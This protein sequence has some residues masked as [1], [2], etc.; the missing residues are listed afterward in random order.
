MKKGIIKWYRKDGTG[1]IIPDNS[2]ETIYFDK[3]VFCKKYLKME[4]GQKVK[5]KEIILYNRR[6]ATKI[7]KIGRMGK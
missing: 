6:V 4:K 2:T 3:S 7:Q 5:F 1:Y